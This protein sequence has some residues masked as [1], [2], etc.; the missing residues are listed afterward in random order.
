M[1][2]AGVYLLF[3]GI[4][5]FV[6]IYFGVDFKLLSLLDETFG[7]FI[8]LL[9]RLLCVIIG[10]ILIIIGLFKK[11]VNKNNHQ[12][13]FE[14]HETNKDVE[15]ELKQDSVDFEDKK[16]ENEKITPEEWLKLNS[17][18]SLNDY[19]SYINK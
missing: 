15:N 12:N 7:F 13:Y 11:A 18:K 14:G 8:G 3:F 2:K 19:Y 10:V 5:S 4:G 1:I 9:I 6:L 17:G 16:I